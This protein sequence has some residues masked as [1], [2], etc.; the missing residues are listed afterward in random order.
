MYTH[1]YCYSSLMHFWCIAHSV[2]FTC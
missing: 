2:V 1:L